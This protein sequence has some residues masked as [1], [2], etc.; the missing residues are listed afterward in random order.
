MELSGLA[1]VT[2]AGHRLGRAMALDLA[3][4]GYIM[5]NGKI[6]LD[7]PSERLMADQDVREF[8]LGH[9]EGAAAKKRCSALFC[10]I[11]LVSRCTR[12]CSVM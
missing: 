6:Q 2:G 11:A 1:L 4:H 3:D 9:A 8:Y 5:E 12:T 7:G 10:R